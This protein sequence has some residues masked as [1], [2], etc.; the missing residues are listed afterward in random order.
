MNDKERLVVLKAFQKVLDSAVDDATAEVKAELWER[1]GGNGTGDDVYIG[2]TKSKVAFV[3]QSASKQFIGRGEEFE[4]FMRDHGM[5]KE[6]IDDGWTKCVVQAGD[7]V[8]WEETGEVVPGVYISF[9]E[10]AA[11][12]TVKIHEPKDVLFAAH[13]AGMLDGATLQMLGEGE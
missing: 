6:V 2:D 13:Y 11:Y 9:K 3:G 7:R 8:L 1:N 12:V 5:V 4:Q 10:R